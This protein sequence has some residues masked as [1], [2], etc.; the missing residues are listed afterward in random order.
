VAVVADGEE[1]RF[2]VFTRMASKL[3]MMYFEMRHTPTELASPAVPLQDETVQLCILLTIQPDRLPP[4]KV[5]HAG[6][7]TS[8]INNFCCSGSRNLKN[9]SCE[10]N[11]RFGL[12]LSKLAPARKSA[13]II[14]K[15]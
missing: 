2:A 11:R 5:A 10:L 7:A 14:S 3:L 9:R 13:Q 8:A 4:G 1:I 6:L 12:P 15:Q